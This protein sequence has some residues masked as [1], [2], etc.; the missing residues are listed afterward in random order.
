MAAVCFAVLRFRL[1]RFLSRAKG[2]GRGVWEGAREAAAAG[3]AGVIWQKGQGGGD[4]FEIGGGVRSVTGST[5]SDFG[6]CGVCA[7]RGQ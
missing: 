4:S 1:G 5:R 2:W 7:V 6:G 3:G